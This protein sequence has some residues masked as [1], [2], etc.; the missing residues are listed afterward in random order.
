[1]AT[2]TYGAPG[3]LIQEQG[4]LRSDGLDKILTKYVNS[5]LSVPI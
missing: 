5:L 1:M 3:R 2:A 4:D